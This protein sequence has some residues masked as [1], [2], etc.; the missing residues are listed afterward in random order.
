MRLI[1]LAASVASV[2]VARMLMSS[3]SHTVNGSPARSDC[4]RLATK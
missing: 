1:S 3:A 4:T 2:G